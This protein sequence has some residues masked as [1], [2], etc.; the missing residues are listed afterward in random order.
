MGLKFRYMVEGIPEKFDFY[1]G[2]PFYSIKKE[3]YL[4]K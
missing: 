2:E 4:Q 3:E 1:N